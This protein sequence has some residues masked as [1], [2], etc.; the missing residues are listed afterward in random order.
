MDHGILKLLV[1]LPQGLKTGLSRDQNRPVVHSREVT[2]SALMF[3]RDTGSVLQNDRQR[4]CENKVLREVL[5]CNEGLVE[6]TQSGASD[7]K[8]CDRGNKYQTWGE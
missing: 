8:R 3:H 1:V 2:A 7:L 6:I 4:A 5:Y